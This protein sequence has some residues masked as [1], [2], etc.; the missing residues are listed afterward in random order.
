MALGLLNYGVGNL[1][2]LGNSLTHLGIPFRIASTADDLAGLSHVLLP[3]VGAFAPAMA[4]L[5][6]RRL[7]AALRAHVQAGGRLLGICLGMQLLF[8]S[9]AEGGRHPGLGL[10]P[11]SVEPLDATDPTL[12]I[13]HM[14]WNDVTAAPHSRLLTGCGQHP[15]FY[16]VHSYRCLPTDATAITGTCVYGSAFA[17]VVEAGTVMGCQF[18]PEKSQRNGLAVLRAFAELPC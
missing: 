7:D 15:D 4:C 5:R 2:S 11:G 10:V 18:H 13:P 16:F 9:S 1:G 6:E 12:R 8:D 17:A 3:G 14:G